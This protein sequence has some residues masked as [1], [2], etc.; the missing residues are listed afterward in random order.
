[1]T[2]ANSS[3]GIGKVLICLF[4]AY[5]P[6]YANTHAIFGVRL[7]LGNADPKLLRERV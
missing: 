4:L 6:Y 1:M 5:C 3:S 2:F 7:I